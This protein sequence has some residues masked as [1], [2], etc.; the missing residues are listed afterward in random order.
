MVTKGLHDGENGLLLKPPRTVLV[1][2]FVHADKVHAIPTSS[3]SAHYPNEAAPCV[4]LFIA[5][6]THIRVDHKVQIC[7]IMHDLLL[8]AIVED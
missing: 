6:L 7:Q 4:V 8:E 2:H 5:H 3:V 1:G